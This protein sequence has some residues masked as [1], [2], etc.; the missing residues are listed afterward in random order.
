MTIEEALNAKL[1]SV[2]AITDIVG[3]RIY[4][5]TA[6]EGAAKP[7]L[8]FR[9]RDRDDPACLSGEQQV[10]VRDDF[11]FLNEGLERKELGQVRDAI[12]T[13][14]NG[15]VARGTWGGVSGIT[16]RGCTFGSA[17]ANYEQAPDASEQHRRDA[18]LDMT[19]IW[20]RG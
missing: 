17:S 19:V 1:L 8:I 11:E 4:P 16:V 5:D 3:T 14:L 9:Q 10:I 15:T 13:A 6:P 12:V 2:T 20:K 18:L 7:Y